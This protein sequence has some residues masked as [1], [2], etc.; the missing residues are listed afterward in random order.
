VD[1]RAVL[2]RLHRRHDPALPRHARSR[3][4]VEEAQFRA[5]LRAGGG[6]TLGFMGTWPGNSYWFTADGQGAVAYRVIRKIALTM[7]DPV[8]ARR[9][10][11]DRRGLHRLLRIAGLVRLLLQLPRALPPIF[12]S[13]GWQYMSVGEETVIDLPVSSWRARHGRR[14]GSR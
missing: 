9:R 13:F 12:Q 3:D 8:C 2:D 1:R 14:C 10:A 5:L 4:A 11:G 6:G 7:S